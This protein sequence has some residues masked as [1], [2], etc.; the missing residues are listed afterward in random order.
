MRC[1]RMALLLCC[2]LGG[3]T[4]VVRAADWGDLTG[5]LLYDGAAPARQRLVVDKDLECCGKY[6]DEIVDEAVTVGPT[7]GLANVFVYVR[8]ERGKK[9][10]VHPDLEKA[11]SK[12]AVLDNLH[13]RFQPHAL[14]V[15]GGK[16]TLLATNSDPI[17]HAVKVDF[18][19]NSPVNNLLPPAAKLEMKFQQAESLPA[20]VSCGP[21]PWERAYV[22]VHDS[23][24]IA[25]TDMNGQFTIPKLPAGEWEFQFWHEKVGFLEAK[26]TWAKGRV[27]LPI[28]AGANDIGQ[29]K[30]PAALFTKK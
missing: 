7:G 19:K 18:L 11:A 24:S 2:V 8:L 30:V 5:T 22:K 17:G 15:W 1:S 28:K 21:H 4:A 20:Q 9:I 13:C 26:P 29:I 12:P 16:Q 23:P 27:K 6:L 3:W 25:V 10:T 14:A